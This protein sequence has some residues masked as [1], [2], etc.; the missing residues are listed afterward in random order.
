MH[1]AFGVIPIVLGVSAASCGASPEPE[2]TPIATIASGRSE[3]TLRPNAYAI[4]VAASVVEEA[5]LEFA[6]PAGDALLARRPGDAIVGTKTGFL[7]KVRAVRATASTVVVDTEPAG[8]VDVFESA[9][10]HIE[11]VGVPDVD[12]G[13]APDAEGTL[14]PLSNTNSRGAQFFLKV[15]D[16]KFSPDPRARVDMTVG[17]FHYTPRLQF[18]AQISGAQLRYLRFAFDG[19]F[20]TKSA[21]RLAVTGPAYVSQKVLPLGKTPSFTFPVPI[22]PVTV[23]IAANMEFYVNA[24][25]NAG[26][27]SEASVHQVVTVS[28][29]LLVGFECYG[30]RCA[31][32]GT[33]NFAFNPSPATVHARGTARGSV[34]IAGKVNVKAADIVG[35]FFTVTPYV[36]I[37]AAGAGGP[38]TSNV[39]VGV[40]GEA[41]G[42][43]RI[44]DRFAVGFQGSLFDVSRTVATSQSGQF[45]ACRGQATG[46][47]WATCNRSG[48][49][50]NYEPLDAC[51]KSGGGAACFTS[52]SRYRST[53][54]GTASG[55]GYTC[56]LDG[57]YSCLCHQGGLACFDTYC[58]R[59]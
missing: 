42:E 3:A 49:V 56:H 29:R 55:G 15:G 9:F 36:G 18:D 32:L 34:G 20:Y 37:D 2:E 16:T 24:S 28:S 40:K 8:L 25:A 48:L 26:Q 51:V 50:T 54:C 35:P 4:D 46:A 38:T 59:N 58:R 21:A 41:G 10:V 57:M 45:A 17:E 27:G 31:P 39:R 12:D 5:H 47:G 19:D 23:P 1:R 30:T 7:R 52:T 43:L 6:R 33:Q 11:A 53:L 22:G 14:R 13:A 44:L